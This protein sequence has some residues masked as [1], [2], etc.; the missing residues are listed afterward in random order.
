[1]K[2]PSA[3]RLCRLVQ[4]LKSGRWSWFAAITLKF[5]HEVLPV[6]CPTVFRHEMSTNIFRLCFQFFV[7]A[8]CLAQL[9]GSEAAVARLHPEPT[10]VLRKLS[11]RTAGLRLRDAAAGN[12]C[13]ARPRGKHIYGCAMCCRCCCWPAIALS[14]WCRAFACLMTAAVTHGCWTLRDGKERSINGSTE[15]R[16]A[17]CLRKGAPRTRKHSSQRQ[18]HQVLARLHLIK[19]EEGVHACCGCRHGVIWRSSCIQCH[20]ICACPSRA[21]QPFCVAPN[22]ACCGR[23][24]LH[25]RTTLCRG[26]VRLESAGGVRLATGLLLCSGLVAQTGESTTN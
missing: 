8:A 11:L 10:V 5:L 9:V 15:D 17:C 4:S 3:F 16:I 21:R 12:L 25:S 26:D 18:R 13:L 6:Q 22:N 14:A 20:C 7:Y 1:M 24:V 23:G 2:C 19:V